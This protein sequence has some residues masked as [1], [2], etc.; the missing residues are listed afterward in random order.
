MGKLRLG[1]LVLVAILTAGCGL[2]NFGSKLPVK[3]AKDWKHVTLGANDPAK[4]PGIYFRDV[5]SGK[6]DAWQLDPA[7]IRTLWLSAVI[8]HD[9]VAVISGEEKEQAP[10]Y[11]I[12]RGTGKVYEWAW[13]SLRFVAAASDRLVFRK[14][15]AGGRLGQFH[16]TDMNLKPLAEFKLPVDVKGT[17]LAAISPDGATVALAPIPEPFGAAEPQH[18]TLFLVTLAD[19]S[20]RQ[21]ANPPSGARNLG[22]QPFLRAERNGSE[23]VL[24]YNDGRDPENPAVLRRY[25]W[26]GTP[27]GEMTAPGTACAFT[28]DGSQV[29]CSGGEWPARI[30]VSDVAAGKPLYRILGGVDPA[31]TADGSQVVFMRS[32]YAGYR[33][34][35]PAGRITE[36]A[37]MKMGGLLTPPSPSPTDPNLFAV[38]GRVVDGAGKVQSQVATSEALEFGWLLPWN[39]SGTEIRYLLKEARPTGIEEELDFAFEPVLQKAPF[40][41]DIAL[42]IKADPGDCLNLRRE[43]SKK[44]TI[45]RCLPGG[46]QVSLQ[47]NAGGP[48]VADNERWVPVKTRQ[49]EA[50]W[51]AI[52]TG[53]VSYAE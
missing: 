7:K 49:G 1:A 38:Q 40:P 3:S 12:N 15:A 24:G 6:T 23:F 34:A 26:D 43:A 13:D 30:V 42:R 50:G 41:A 18:G 53:N 27:L 48:T 29:A 8:P 5:K 46:T 25:S 39:Q 17:V 32:N 36:T 47:A 10:V 14:P 21:V 45:I 22:M 9:S 35:A 31:W 28:R 52:S 19:G 20:V 11:L 4:L 37:A 33:I 16:I 2:L 51:I 44:G